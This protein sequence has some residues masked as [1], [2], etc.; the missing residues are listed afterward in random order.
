MVCTDMLDLALSSIHAA[1]KFARVDIDSML[2][3]FNSNGSAQTRP[4]ILVVDD[5]R[6]IADTISEILGGAG[7][8]V[9]VAYDGSGALGAIAQFQPDCLLSDVLMPR[10]N[11]VELAIAVRRICPETRI[12]LFSGQAGISEI[13]LDAQRLGLDFELIPKP[14]HPL[15]LIELIKEG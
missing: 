1:D 6:L 9:M 2:Q 8:E 15:K 3:K 11:G 14:I 7:F 4:R 10:M 5:E 13:L 12:I